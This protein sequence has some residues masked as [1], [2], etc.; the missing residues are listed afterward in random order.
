MLELKYV[1]HLKRYGEKAL[2]Y[3]CAHADLEPKS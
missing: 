1:P 3:L 2:S